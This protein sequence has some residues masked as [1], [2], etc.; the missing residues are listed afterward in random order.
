M[1]PSVTPPADNAPAVRRR[2]DAA[3]QPADDGQSARRK[4]RG[5]AARPPTDRRRTPRVRRQS[6]PPGR[7]NAALDPC[8]QRTGGG[9]AM[10]VNATGYDWVAPGDVARSVSACARSMAARG[11]RTRPTGDSDRPASARPA[12]GRTIAAGGSPARSRSAI[13]QPATRT[14]GARA[15]CKSNEIGHGRTPSG[16]AAT[17][18]KKAGATAPKR[19]GT[20]L[21]STI[22]G[23]DRGQSRPRFVNRLSAIARKMAQF[24]SQPWHTACCSLAESRREYGIVSDKSV[25][26]LRVALFMAAAAIVSAGTAFADA[27]SDGQGA[28]RIRHQRRAARPLAR[29]HLPLGKATEIDP[30]LRRRVQRPGDCVRARRSA[31]QSPQGIREVRLE[32]DPNNAAGPSELRAVQGNQ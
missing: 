28:G 31:R 23:D 26:I 5:R 21:D 20:D 30:D 11:A 1:M 12:A 22:I 19:A 29:S 15:R 8:I 10:V 13:A 4:I 18:R 32:L 17:G 3:R 24:R 2:V 27:R 6:R 25:M 16:G 7:S 9:S 14:A